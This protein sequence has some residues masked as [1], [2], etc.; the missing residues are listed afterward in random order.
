MTTAYKYLAHRA[1]VRRATVTFPAGSPVS[2]WSTLIEEMRCLLIWDEF[3][4]IEGQAI[5]GTA[6]RQGIL[7]VP[8]DVLLKKDDRLS[9][10]GPNQL[11]TLK[12]T[13]YGQPTLDRHSKVSHYEWRVC[14]V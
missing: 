4:P 1:Q 2:V 8:N 10:L 13:A 12:I 9:M 3:A 11:G 5:S 7:M 14:E 6:K